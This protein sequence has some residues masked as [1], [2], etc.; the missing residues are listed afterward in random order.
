MASNVRAANHQ[1]LPK[2]QTKVLL[3]MSTARFE[4]ESVSTFA[5]HLR[6]IPLRK[7]AKVDNP[8]S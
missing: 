4:E 2:P 8:L 5:G 6:E 3:V 7:V 1:Q